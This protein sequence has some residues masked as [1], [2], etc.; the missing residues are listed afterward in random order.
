MTGFST[1]TNHDL[2]PM[3]GRRAVLAGLA[4]PMFGAALMRPAPLSAAPLSSATLKL[5]PSGRISFRVIRENKHIGQHELSFSAAPDGLKIAISVDIVVRLGPIPVFRYRLAG[6]ETWQA[7]ALAG[8]EARTNNDG[9]E[10]HMQ[11]VRDATGL[12]VS[13]ARSTRSRIDRYRAPDDARL[14]THWNIAQLTGPWIN[15]QNGELLHPSITSHQPETLIVPPGRPVLARR[16]DA[17]GDVLLSL[18]YDG[19]DQWAALRFHARDNS[20]VTYE[21]VL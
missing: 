20:L 6:T 1:S 2:T 5:P 15:P 11:A 3:P 16:H 13:G 7:G 17:T 18:W 12:W 21:R 14:A 19:E 8:A 9:H 4:A 10:E